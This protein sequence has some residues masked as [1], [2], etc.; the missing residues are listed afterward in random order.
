MAGIPAKVLGSLR[1]H[2]PSLTMKHGKQP[3]GDALLLRISF[4]SLFYPEDHGP[5]SR[6]IAIIVKWPKVVDRNYAFSVTF[7]WNIFS[8]IDSYGIYNYIYVW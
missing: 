2:D 1:E 7:L 5:V 8:W 3:L 6:L 4:L